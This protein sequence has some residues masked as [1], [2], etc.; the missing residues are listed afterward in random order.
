MLEFV[1]ERKMRDLKSFKKKL[2]KV[3]E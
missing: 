2:E 1:F 3:M